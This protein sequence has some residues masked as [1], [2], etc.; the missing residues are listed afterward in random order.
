MKLLIMGKTPTE[1]IKALFVN[2]TRRGRVQLV[3]YGLVAILAFI[4]DFGLLYVFAG[5]FHWFYLL[6][7]TLSFAL[8]VIVNYY[9]ST[10]WV[11]AQRNQRQRSLEII[12]FISICFVALLLNDLFMWIFVSL[13]DIHYL[14]SKLITVMIVFI[15]S[16]GARR[17]MFHG[18]LSKNK[19]LRKIA[20]AS[21]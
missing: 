21:S 4:V 10:L 20:G 9:L 6:S 7:A 2:P 13:A 14:L 18:D 17:I 1:F 19:L 11:F 16:F 15:W 12:I 5:L 8:S 3:R